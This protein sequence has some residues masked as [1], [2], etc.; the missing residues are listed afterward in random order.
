ME[1]SVKP[2]EPGTAATAV[3]PATAGAGEREGSSHIALIVA[4]FVYGVVIY[5]TLFADPGTFTSL[6]E[7]DRWIEG[8]GSLALLAGSIFF[9]LSFRASRRLGEHK[10]K[11]LV[12]ISLAV[13]FFVG[14]GE[15]ISWGQRII[16]Y[17]TPEAVDHASSQR[18]LNL[19]NLKSV[20]GI[21]N[22]DKLFQLFWFGF[23]FVLPLL[24]TLSRSA[25]EWLGRFLPIVPL[26]VGLVL[27]ANQFM[28]W[29]ARSFFDDRFYNGDGFG[30]HYSVFEMK[31]SV[32]EMALGIG[33]YC[34]Y[35]G[36]RRSRR[37]GGAGFQLPWRR[38]PLQEQ[39]GA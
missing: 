9:F 31:E 8:P 1:G 22:P 39:A 23:G 12:L 28:A 5:L 37:G 11:Q 16:G 19:H 15:E 13:L 35:A 30:L 20:D 32:A 38:Q 18:E 26:G 21:L 25:R 10:I 4:G 24:A 17:G 6:I 29:G 27:V 3:T 14:F 7:E 36:Y 34:V 2:T 33:A